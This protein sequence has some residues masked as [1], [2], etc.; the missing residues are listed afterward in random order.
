MNGL[1]MENPVGLLFKWHYQRDSNYKLP[2]Y[3]EEKGVMLDEKQ[4]TRMPKHL[5][6]TKQRVVDPLLAETLE[7]LDGKT[8]VWIITGKKREEE[9]GI[10]EP[11]VFGLAGL[12]R[13]ETGL[14]FGISNNVG[15]KPENLH[16]C[17]LAN[18]VL[19]LEEYIAHRE[20][21]LVFVSCDGLHYIITS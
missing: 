2:A 11:V 17:T 9:T 16:K 10:F 13:L 14:N 7:G 21:E 20:M 12:S 19:N 6:P 15:L 4:F 18:I 8:D 3:N 5:N 1:M